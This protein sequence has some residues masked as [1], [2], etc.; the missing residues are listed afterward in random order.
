MIVVIMRVWTQRFFIV[1]TRCFWITV[2]VA[3]FE[4]GW[5]EQKFVACY[6]QLAVVYIGILAVLHIDNDACCIL[7]LPKCHM[8]AY[9]RIF[10]GCSWYRGR[11]NQHPWDALW[12]PN[13][14]ARI[15]PPIKMAIID[16]KGNKR[17]Q[18]QVPDFC[19][20]SLWRC[21]QAR[22]ILKPVYP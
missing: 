20:L 12:N 19:L 1:T 10:K 5:K 4:G 16:P 2:E 17:S 15:R 11:P 3:R 7:L 8:L 22:L 9:I 6:R 21:N 13:P 14:Q 18:K